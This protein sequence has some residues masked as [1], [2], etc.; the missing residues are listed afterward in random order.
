MAKMALIC[1]V[2]ASP[3]CCPSPFGRGRSSFFPVAG[4]GAGFS[5]ARASVFSLSRSRQAQRSRRSARVN[6]SSTVTLAGLPLVRFSREIAALMV[7][8]RV[9]TVCLTPSVIMRS[10][11]VVSSVGKEAPPGAPFAIYSLTAAA[12]GCVPTTAARS[13]PCCFRICR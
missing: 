4:S 10:D 5:G 13:A 8:R 3:A 12:R 11:M 7:E 2:L 9:I 6:T 1:L